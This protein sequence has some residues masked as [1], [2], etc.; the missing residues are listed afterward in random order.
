MFA[1]PNM[2]C[3]FVYANDA[4]VKRSASNATPGEAIR[5]AD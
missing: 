4:A 3:I 2:F 5:K 1:N